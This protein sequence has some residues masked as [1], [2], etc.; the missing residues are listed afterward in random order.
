M[1]PLLYRTEPFYFK[2]LIQYHGLSIKAADKTKNQPMIE[3]FT[4]YNYLATINQCF[5]D[6]PLGDIIDR[7]KSTKMPFNF[8]VKR[9]WQIPELN[10]PIQ[11]ED[12]FEERVK[13]LLLLNQKLNLFWSGGIDSTSM[14]VGF[15]LNC[16]DTSKFRIVY[17][18]ESMKENPHFFL[19][20]EAMDNIELFDYSG[21]VYLNQ[22][23][24]GL[25]V[26]GDVSDEIT[27]SMDQSYFDKVGFKKLYS[28]WKEPFYEQVQ[29]H[30]FI[31]FCEQWFNKSGMEINTLLKARWWFYIAS[32]YQVYESKAAMLCHDDQPLSIGFYNTVKFEHYTAQNVD[33][34]FAGNDYNTYKQFF[35]DYIYQFDKNKLY[36]KNKLK[37]GSWQILLYREKKRYLQK[38]DIMLLSDG[39]RICTDNLP[40]LS[41]KEYRNKYN[42]SLDYLF[43][44]P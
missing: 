8:I 23:L 9:P 30:N 1:Q 34:L 36:N 13:E 29:D 43:N 35:K 20:L 40:F 26:T 7:T 11:L 33:K 12:C 16:P 21:E 41:E 28:S 6:F 44:S 22:K 5:S 15:L 37:T 31:D 19:M 3:G 10:T 39:T 42:T 24:D 14:I 38:Q 18:P 17:S 25:I 2:K 4:D 32:K 27:A